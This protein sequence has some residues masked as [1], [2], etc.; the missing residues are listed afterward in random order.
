MWG[1]S[2]F[3]N[4]SDRVYR[5]N[6]VSFL[7]LLDEDPDARVLD[8]GCNDG[9][10]SREI[11]CRTKAGEIFGVERDPDL[12]SQALKKGIRITVCD[13]NSALPFKDSSFDLITVNQL[14]EHLYD[15]DNF[16]S[17]IKRV[18]KSGGQA[19]VS[20]INLSSWHNIFFSALGMQPP[21]MHLCK[22]QVGNFLSGTKTH[23]HTR[24]LTLLAFK[25]ISKDYGLK[26]EKV[27]ASGYYP[28]IGLLG[29][30]LSSWDKIHAV[31]ISLGLRK[32]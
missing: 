14:I 8:I 26:V 16:F 15:L 24:L 17:E 4:I 18:L 12:A 27:S 5:D 1:K 30:M 28:F 29:D 21:S 19:I 10:L 23:G 20:T 32:E 25:A 3:L 9:S 31:Y 6:Q 13:A 7:R 22:V 11:A 2:I